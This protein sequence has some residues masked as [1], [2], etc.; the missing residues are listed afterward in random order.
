[1]PSDAWGTPAVVCTEVCDSHKDELAEYFCNSHSCPVCANCAIYTH[2]ECNV[3]FIP[4]T[5]KTFKDSDEYQRFRLSFNKIHDDLNKFDET[6][7][8]RRAA[9]VN[10][11]HKFRQEIN[12]YLDKVGREMVVE[13][14]KLYEDKATETCN[15]EV[16][17]IQSQLTENE[18]H[19][20]NLYLFV[21]RKRLDL[22]ELKSSIDQL[23]KKPLRTYRFKPL[24]KLLEIKNSGCSFGEIEVVKY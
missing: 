22:R 5:A 7:S 10:D 6:L 24:D 12:T 8:T 23:T 9:V 1:M 14:K 20:V 15:T 17:F 18:H 16:E 13:A 3:D 2:R 19:P 11:I 4:T 21:K